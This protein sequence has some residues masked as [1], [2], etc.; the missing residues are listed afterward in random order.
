MVRKINQKTGDTFDARKEIERLQREAELLE[1]KADKRIHKVRKMGFLKLFFLELRTGFWRRY[2]EVT[3]QT[4][5]AQFWK[6]KARALRRKAK[7][8]NQRYF[9]M[10]YASVSTQPRANLR[11]VL[12]LLWILIVAFLG[13][14]AFSF[15][16]RDF[17]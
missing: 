12:V 13:F 16:K 7:R 9:N 2:G 11:L 10:P 3:R 1:I 17:F 6:R 8:L 4:N 15:L 5:E 14:I